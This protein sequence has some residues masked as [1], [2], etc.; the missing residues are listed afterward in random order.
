MSALRVENTSSSVWIHMGV[1][2]PNTTRLGLPV[3][4]AFKTARGGGLGGLAGAA[5]RPSSPMHR[6]WDTFE[7]MFIGVNVDVLP[8]LHAPFIRT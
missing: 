3:R 7:V 5:V 8:G 2:Y 1:P 6:V 4:T